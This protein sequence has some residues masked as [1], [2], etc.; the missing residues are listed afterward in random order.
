MATDVTPKME[1]EEWKNLKRRNFLMAE[2]RP[3]DANPEGYDDKL[4]FWI[5]NINKWSNHP[6]TV[7]FT[8][9]NIQDSFESEGRV[10]ESNCVKRVLSHMMTKGLVMR[11]EDYFQRIQTK[12]RQNSSWVSWGLTQA[13]KPLSYGWSLVSYSLTPATIQSNNDLSITNN[14]KLISVE[15]FESLANDLYK[16]M[17][18]KGP[19]VI[20]YDDLKS[21]ASDLLNITSASTLDLILSYLE[22]EGRVAITS[23]CGIRLVKFGP[24]TVSFSQM[25]IGLA[26]L[27][28]AKESISSDIKKLEVELDQ[29]ESEARAAVRDKQKDKALKHLAK[30][31]KIQLLLRKKEGQLDNIEFLLV[32][33][34][35]T[36]SNLIIV[37][38]FQQAAD[39][40][41][42]ANNRQAEVTKVIDDVEDVIAVQTETLS[43]LLRPLGHNDL[44]DD[45]QLEQELNDLMADDGMGVGSLGPATLKPVSSSSSTAKLIPTKPASKASE[46]D[47]QLQDL[48]DRLEKLRT[49][50]LEDSLEN[51]LN[52]DDLKDDVTKSKMAKGRVTLH[53]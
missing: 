53:S 1:P 15:S 44:M 43:E 45:S 16:R 39:V 8:V 14:E 32:Q 37:D 20:K 24:K 35:D 27:E 47:K 29:I 17:T 26:R 34:A 36:D 21:R 4:N 3:R 12:L 13:T 50:H 18:E 22:S 38:A 30:K 41:K 2:F 48:M 49:D 46:A 52:D 23:D 25:D 7:E 51:A 19:H 42:D 33:M 40:L 10:P 9:K 28:S 31:K 11:R 5:R 6:S